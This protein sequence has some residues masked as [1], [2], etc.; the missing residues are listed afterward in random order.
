MTDG[1]FRHLQQAW[2]V[3]AL[4]TE[5]GAQMLLHRKILGRSTVLYRRASG[6][7]VAL[8]D[9]CPHRFVRLSMGK[10]EGD[11]V[12]CPYHALR[13]DAAGHCVHNPHGDGLIPKAAKVQAY[14]VV[15]RDGFLWLWAGDTT[16]ADPALI[17]DYGL[18]SD[19]H[20]HSKGYAYLH[21]RAHYEIVVDN[22]M[23]LSHV[24]H[25]HGPLLNTA[26]HLSAQQPQVREDGRTVTVRWDW[27][28]DP[29]MGFFS[30]FLKRPGEDA[31]HHVTV[32]WTAPSTMLLTVGAAQD[33][34]SDDAGL[35]SW[36]HHLMTPETETTTHYFFGS[37]RNWG[38][39]DA[40][41]NRMKLE[42]TVA[43]FTQEDKPIIEMVQQEMGTTDLW[44]LKPVL[45][46][47]DPAAVRARRVLA[48]L[49]DAEGR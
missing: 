36:D 10:R 18:L 23:D 3:A 4:S 45:L 39:E 6:E 12:V 32:A 31:R 21:M 17:P 15:E 42:G 28:Q 30:P 14:P 11:D 1:A 46:T 43:A 25:V 8:H 9:R 5:V 27:V 22:I 16:L 29:P 38:V 33:G 24:D 48:K 2:Y 35:L 49:I 7:P 26:G 13:F 40:E 44:S 37:R 41:L 20:A 19:G 47:S 34:D